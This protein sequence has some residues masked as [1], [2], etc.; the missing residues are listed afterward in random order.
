MDHFFL[1]HDLLLTI[2]VVSLI[3]LCLTSTLSYIISTITGVLSSMLQRGFAQKLVAEA[4]SLNKLAQAQ[5]G[6]RTVAGF[7]EVQRKQTFH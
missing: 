2:L 7:S 3:I 5:Q 6:Y 4:E 1:I